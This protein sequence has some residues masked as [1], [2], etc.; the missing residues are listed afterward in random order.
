MNLVFSFDSILSAMALT[1]IFWVMAVAIVISGILMIWLS[2]KVSKFLEKNRL[3][4]LHV[5]ENLWCWCSL[6]PRRLHE[7]IKIC[8]EKA[9][10]LKRAKTNCPLPLACRRRF[11]FF[12][13]PKLIPNTPNG[14]S[15]NC[16]DPKGSPDTP[17]HWQTYNRAAAGFRNMHGKERDPGEGV[18]APPESQAG[19]TEGGTDTTLT[20]VGSADFNEVL[21]MFWKCFR[22]DLG[23][24]CILKI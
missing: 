2:D 21:G 10:F 20:P 11:L 13:P 5:D 16:W 23:I 15:T 22:N 8:W 4:R 17:K 12:L 9:C 3:F 6:L 24:Y 19:G 14:F 18:T 1:D 7:F